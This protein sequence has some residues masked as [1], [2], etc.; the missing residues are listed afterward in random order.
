MTRA[1]QAPHPGRR[2]GLSL[3]A[4]IALVIGVLSFLPNVV[5][6]LLVLLPAF[7]RMSGGHGIPWL[8]VAAWFMVAACFAAG[9]GYLLSRQLLSPLSRLSTQ[10]GA[11]RQLSSQGG[12]RQLPIEDDEPTETLHLKE[13]FN[14][15]IRHLRLEQARRGSSTATLVHDLKTPL[16]A[17]V[18]LLKVIG[19]NDALSREE[20]INLVNELLR[21]HHALLDLVQ[22]L[23]DA[24]KCEQ[25]EIALNVR[26]QE[27]APLL[28]RVLKRIMPLARERGVSLSV[29]GEA[30][31]HLDANEF[32]RALYNLV[33]NAVRYAKSY[34]R[35]DIYNGVI[36]LAD[37]GPGLPA[38]LE[39]LA[40]PFNAQPVEIAGQ[41][42]AAGS[43]GLGL[44]IAR[45]IVEAHGGRLVTEASGSGGTVLLIYLK[46]LGGDSRV[47]H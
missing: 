4:Q 25:D 30:C 8:A 21:E 19:E 28:D 14:A 10:I 27:L 42:Y 33:S 17:S 38:A 36:R 3:H 34:V 47:D 13:S 22:K 41:H 46:R 9:I 18:N 31:E 29:T 32:E 35:L 24:H 20:R 7:D 2:L 6:A 12:R 26:R 1:L 16:I 43:A 40:Q 39:Q 15:L 37:D 45:R 23:V 5:V 44:F 11:M